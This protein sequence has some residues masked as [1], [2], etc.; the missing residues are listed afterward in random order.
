MEVAWDN[1]VKT[2][3]TYLVHSLPTIHYCCLKYFISGRTLLEPNNITYSHVCYSVHRLLWQKSRIITRHK[4]HRFRRW[5]LLCRY[6]NG[7]FLYSPYTEY[8]AQNDCGLCHNITVSCIFLQ[9]GYATKAEGWMQGSLHLTCDNE[10]T[11]LPLMFCM[12]LFSIT[13]LYSSLQFR[14][15]TRSHQNQQ[16]TW[17]AKAFVLYCV[18]ITLTAKFKPR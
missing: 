1:F 5:V 7:F 18:Y 8:F 2:P 11:T 13:C 3:F 10:K 6:E 15:I 12:S 14:D 17:S 9:Y 4:K 16:L